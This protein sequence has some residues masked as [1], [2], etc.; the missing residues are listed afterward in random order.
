M[1][2]L[3]GIVG[4]ARFEAGAKGVEVELAG[5]CE[6]VIDGDGEL[7]HRAIEN[8]VRNAVRYS[9][10]QGKVIVEVRCDAPAGLVRIAVKDSGP[11][12]PEED[13]DAIFAP[14]YRSS[15]AKDSD[16]HGLGLA[17]A[18]RVIESKGGRIRG[19][20]RAEGGF[21]M[22]IALPARRPA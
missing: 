2:L 19:T 14:F 11:G 15:G 10:P 12:V 4:D 1:E 6:G 17:I 13:L 9:P 20:N 21:C 18:R 3:S 5:E 22:E 8:V 7:L 16:G